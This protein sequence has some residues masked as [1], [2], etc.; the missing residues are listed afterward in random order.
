MQG[1]APLAHLEGAA[2]EL[3]LKDRVA[4]VT[5]GTRDVGRAIALTLAAEG[6]TV[7]V[8]HRSSP[9]DAEAVVAEIRK[10]GGKTKAYQADI[11]DRAAVQSMIEEIVGEFGGLNILVNNA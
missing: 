6:A 5:G 3:Q 10:Q 8:H 9:E 2:M 4:L 7:A 1:P 11:A